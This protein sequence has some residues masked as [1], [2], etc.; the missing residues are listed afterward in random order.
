MRETSR[1]DK[2]A[3][4]QKQHETGTASQESVAGAVSWQATWNVR[5]HTAVVGDE[6]GVN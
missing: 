4:K 6:M 5:S 1:G 2:E 3:R